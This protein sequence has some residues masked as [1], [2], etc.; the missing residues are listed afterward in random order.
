MSDF[1]LYSQPDT[2]RESFLCGLR[3]FDFQKQV[4]VKYVL[5][6]YLFSPFYNILLRVLFSFAR[7]ICITT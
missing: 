6:K 1:V 5:S 7:V 4:H 3:F 2:Q